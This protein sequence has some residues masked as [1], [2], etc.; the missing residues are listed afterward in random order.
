M[1]GG[2]LDGANDEGGD[3]ADVDEGAAD[4]GEGG[5][6]AAVEDGVDV[7]E[8]DAEA[9]E[10]GGE[11]QWGSEDGALSCCQSGVS[12]GCGLGGMERDR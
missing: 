3:V 9:A 11:V 5:N 4:R 10:R 6:G 7:A 8:A 2:I 1:C 12:A